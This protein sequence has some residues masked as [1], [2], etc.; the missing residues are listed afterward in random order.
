M[1]TIYAPAT[2]PGRAGV[3]VLRLSGPGAFA[4]I[5][6][7]T[8]RPPPPPRMASV[9]RFVDACG[10]PIDRG[11]VL[12]FPGPDSF[13]GED[14]AECHLHGGRAVMAA[15]LDTLATMPGAR[16]AQAGEFSKRAFL[17]GKM[18][19]TEAEGIADLV[20]AETRAQAAQALDQ[21]SG[22]LGRLCDGW[23]DRLVGALAHLEADLDFPD[24]DL[25]GGIAA[26]VRPTLEALKSEIDAHLA[27]RRG[28]RLR[29]GLSV[30]ILGAPN[31]GKS[32]LINRLAGREAAIVAATAGTTRDVIEVAMDLDGYPV[33][34]ADTAGLR[35]AADAVEDEGIRR[36]LDRAERCDLRL[37]L[38]DGRAWPDLDAA[39]LALDGPDAVKLLTKSDLGGP[40][41]VPAGYLSVSAA[42]GA[43]IEALATNLAGAAA[44]RMAGAGP[45]LTRA[46]HRAAL[47]EASAALGRA[48]S[49]ELPA[50]LPELMAE[51]ARL[52][53]RAI[54]RITGRVDVEDLLDV[55]FAD[56]CIGK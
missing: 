42:S 27:D 40:H 16:P 49:P 13:T 53:A 12:V 17:N 52:A 45:A 55:V 20:D 19:L 15:M 31:A 35:Q 48:L 47:S 25:P 18:D 23:R 54:G 30:A 46:R 10:A 3:A 36:A 26:R 4:A 1:E 34:L 29:A 6:A 21:L 38:F 9:R 50:D 32:T 41:P 7:L 39:T 43:G 11:L 14:V 51:D 8:G 2:A 33:Q 44:D 56:F 22:A 37:L 5:E 28:E 24:E